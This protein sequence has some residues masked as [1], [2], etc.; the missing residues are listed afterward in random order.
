M[1]TTMIGIRNRALAYFSSGPFRIPPAV[2]IFFLTVASFFW[3]LGYEVY[4]GDQLIYFFD[5]IKGLD[6]ALFPADILFGTGGFT[7]FDDIILFGVQRLELDI[8]V[9]LF[10]LSFGM[11]YIYFYGVYRILYFF[12]GHTLF[13]VLAP[14]VYFSGF[15]IY[16]T[17]MRTIAPMLLPR[18]IALALCLLA[19]AFLFEKKKLFA[20]F[21]IGLGFLFHPTTPV[22]FLL[23]LYCSYFFERENLFS[24]KS[25][26]TFVIPPFFFFWVYSFVPAGEGSSLFA[27]FDYAWRD[28]ILRRDSY[29]FIS[30]WYF[31]NTSLIYI[32]ASIYLFFL[33]KK[34][35]PEIS[36][37][38]RKKLFFLLSVSIPA[39]LVVVSLIFSDL[40][41]SV[42]ITQLSFGRSLLLW[43]IILNGLFAYYAIRHI[44]SQPKD[45][46]YN[47]LLAS[48]LISFAVNEKLI[49]LFLPAQMFLWSA[50]R[51]G[52]MIVPYGRTFLN[53]IMPSAAV[54]FITASLAGYFWLRN[55]TE[56]FIEA[57]VS[58]VFLS[59]GVVWYFAVSRASNSLRLPVAMGLVCMLMIFF[60][61]RFAPLS[62][63]PS[64]LSYRPFLEACDWVKKNTSKE[65]LFI[66][67]PFTS[68]SG[69]LRLLCHRSLFGTRKDGGQVVFNRE[70]ALEWDRRYHGAIKA[71]GR[72]PVSVIDIAREYKVEYV[73]SDSPLD[74]P[75]KVFDNGVYYVYQFEGNTYD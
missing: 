13:S 73:F 72:D 37:D 27:V 52:E 14:L 46:F 3:F 6:P 34:E 9:I 70:Y 1:H 29:Y 5:I 51:Y 7:F 18:Y 41:S 35:V 50:R 47:F 42:A 71:M 11:R 36:Q 24:L 31:P 61:L 2:F 74:L 8:F 23:I 21:F 59:I 60:Y 39:L 45:I 38:P 53:G 30:T 67:E 69:P 22:P 19:L 40:L 64:A 44:I 12:T 17:G 68:A 57:V 63:H 48:I 20:A 33:I 49:F 10:L 56:G 62:I 28:V 43:K 75:K 65:D 32:A 58:V 54:F 55:N 4:E 26:I 16:G 25:I 66:T 15:V